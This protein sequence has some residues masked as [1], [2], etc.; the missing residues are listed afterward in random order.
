MKE[1]ILENRW[2]VITFDYLKAD[3]IMTEIEN[4]C[5]KTIIRKM[6]RKDE[7]QTEFS[8]GTILMWIKPCENCRGRKYGK[9]WCDEDIDLEVFN[10]LIRPYYFGKYED[11]IWI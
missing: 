8:D 11:I 3:G 9:I 6:K 10:C 1:N 5:D 4:S 2:A 7:I